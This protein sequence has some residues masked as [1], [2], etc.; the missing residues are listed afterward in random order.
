MKKVAMKRK[1]I[2]VAGLHLTATEKAYINAIL[3]AG[4][5]HGHRK[6]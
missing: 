3:D 4:Q 1:I 6:G 5:E 2:L